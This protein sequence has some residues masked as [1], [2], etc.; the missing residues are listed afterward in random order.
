[1]HK[2]MKIERFHIS[3]FLSSFKCFSITDFLQDFSN[4]RI[5]LTS[6]VF[7]FDTMFD[8]FKKK[9]TY[10]LDTGNLLGEAQL[11]ATSYYTKFS[12]ETNFSK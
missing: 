3:H 7:E 1:M 9:K 4:K 11:Q 6:L 12:F 8:G 5:I 10:V 2:V